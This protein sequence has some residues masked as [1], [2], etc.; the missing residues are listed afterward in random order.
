MT[1]KER[2]ILFSGPMVRAV[3][4]GSKTQTRRVV[5]PQPHH[6][7]G[8][9][10]VAHYEP[11]VVNWRGEEEPGS[12]IFG[13]Y[14][15]DGSWGCKCP[16]GAPGDRLWVRESGVISKLRGT[17]EKPGLF[18]HDVPTTPTIGD[19]RVEETRAPGASYNVAGCPRSSALL[20][21]GAKACPSIHMPRWASRI[22]LEVTGVRVERLQDI[23]EAD[24]ESEG[25]DFLRHVPD[26]DETLTPSQLYM[27][28]WD[29][30]KPAAGAAW[31][32][33]PWVWVVEFKR[34]T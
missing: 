19:Y 2:P 31:A 8:S 3:L 14:S 21:Y 4:D 18:R 23:S 5:K 1:M 25:I 34:V 26:A 33:N 11:T 15:E 12:V 16:F 9:I 29:G 13:A 28:L 7:V 6:D 17:L 27:C 30:L 20:S 10:T 24:A 32:D 22:T